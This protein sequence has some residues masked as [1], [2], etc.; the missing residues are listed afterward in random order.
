[1]SV[2]SHIVLFPDFLALLIYVL[3]DMAELPA[4]TSPSL[5]AVE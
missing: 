4:K 3:L 5:I 1:M 2:D